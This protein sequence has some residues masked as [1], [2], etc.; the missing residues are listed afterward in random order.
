ML[1]APYRSYEPKQEEWKY[2]MERS[3]RPI[4]HVKN[5]FDTLPKSVSY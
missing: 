4:A 1:F 2:M 3:S 5:L